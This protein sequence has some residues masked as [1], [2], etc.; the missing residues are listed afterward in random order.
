MDPW[1]KLREFERMNEALRLAAEP[2]ENLNRTYERLA[3]LPAAFSFP[4]QVEALHRLHD[5]SRSYHHLHERGASLGAVGLHSDIQRH[6][7]RF[8]AMTR[9]AQFEELHL[10]DS[11]AAAFAAISSIHEAAARAAESWDRYRVAENLEAFRMSHERLAE[12][13]ALSTPAALGLQHHWQ[14][15]DFGSAFTRVSAYAEMLA[16]SSKIGR[17]QLDI[18]QG[19]SAAGL[20]RMLN[21]MEARCFLD[22]AG[23]VLPQPY[24][25]LGE[26]SLRLPSMRP[27]TTAERRRRLRSIKREEAAPQHTVQA[28]KDIH[29][30]ERT[31]RWVIDYLMTINYGEDWVI[32]RLPIC[33]CASLVGKWRHRGG[34]A[35]DH[36]DW[37]EYAKIMCDPQHHSEV[38]SAGFEDRDTLA[39]LLAN[40]RRLRTAVG[41]ANTFTPQ[42]LLD[43]RLVLATLENGLADAMPAEELDWPS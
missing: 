37:A 26:A 7:E 13:L 15:P 20:P 30:A 32:E 29:A 11:S 3:A 38:F 22:A 25:G 34:D 42:N 10:H 19:L 12:R 28:F 40:A 23:L 2:I 14:T 6:E 17:V 36:A 5:S 41:H 8:R 1:D 18:V 4:P 31:L 16:H 9:F 24:G 39:T 35:L 27:V 33:G 43:L 21:A